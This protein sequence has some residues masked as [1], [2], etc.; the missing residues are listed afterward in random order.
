MFI[1]LILPFRSNTFLEEVI[2]RF[3]GEFRG[4]GNV[5]LGE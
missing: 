5:V 4:R 2:V 3:E 1:L